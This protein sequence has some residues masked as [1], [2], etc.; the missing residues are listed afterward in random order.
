MVGT[1]GEPKLGGR[2]N[3]NQGVMS[4]PSAGLAGTSGAKARLAAAVVFSFSFIALCA[5]VN[6]THSAVA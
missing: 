4:S 6:D 1:R 3:R 2:S 5:T